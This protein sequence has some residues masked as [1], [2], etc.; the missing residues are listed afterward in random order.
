M[1]GCKLHCYASGLE[2][3]FT[4]LVTLA[5]AGLRVQREQLKRP[6]LTSREAGMGV[7]SVIETKIR[8]SMLPASSSAVSASMPCCVARNMHAGVGCIFDCQEYL[9]REVPSVN[10]TWAVNNH[11]AFPWCTI[12]SHPKP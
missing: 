5:T 10:S 1:E 4:P 3:L 12:L 11:K 6:M 7:L 9:R 2:H 8:V